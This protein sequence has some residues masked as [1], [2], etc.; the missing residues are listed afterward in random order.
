M[1]LNNKKNIPHLDLI[2]DIINMIHKKEIISHNM[3][4][5]L[6]LDKLET[7]IISDKLETK[8]I[9]DKLETKIILREMLNLK[10]II[11]EIIEEVDLDLDQGT[12][13]DK[14]NLIKENLIMMKKVEMYLEAIQN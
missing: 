9:S 10:E 12:D 11:R 5:D 2:G 13:I 3:K 7:K 6:I 4:I 8:I 14:N 1:L